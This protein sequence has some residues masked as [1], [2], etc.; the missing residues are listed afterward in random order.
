MHIHVHQ[1]GVVHIIILCVFTYPHK[2]QS[3]A[4]VC[5]CVCTGEALC[6][7]LQPLVYSGNA[8]AH[9]EGLRENAHRLQLVT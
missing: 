9:E 4:L 8:S 2:T 3:T 1:Q 6:S 5:V 7:E